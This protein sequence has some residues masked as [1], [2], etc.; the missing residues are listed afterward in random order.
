MSAGITFEYGLPGLAGLVFRRVRCFEI[1]AVQVAMWDEGLRAASRRR[2]RAIKDMPATRH[3]R[4]VLEPD[5]VLQSWTVLASLIALIALLVAHSYGMTWI[6]YAPGAAVLAAMIVASALLKYPATYIP[7]GE[8][9]L[10]IHRG[11]CHDAILAE[12]SRRKEAHFA[13]M[14]VIDP[15]KSIRDN[16]KMLRWLVDIDAIPIETY[17]R[18][19]RTLAPALAHQARADQP[20]LR[21]EQRRYL[22][23]T[24]FDMQSDRVLYESR[25]FG[26]GGS[27]FSVDYT[28]LPERSAIKEKQTGSPALVAT[29]LI[30][31]LF[32]GLGADFLWFAPYNDILESAI[33]MMWALIPIGL[34]GRALVFAVQEFRQGFFVIQEADIRGDEIIT[35]LYKRQTVAWRALA[36]PDPVL[37]LAEQTARLT[38]LKDTGVITD[39][40]LRR[41]TAE[42]ALH[43]S[44][45]LDLLPGDT[46]QRPT[47]LH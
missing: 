30:A 46:P 40:E 23:S 41:F 22:N 10:I 36:A 39:D 28:T 32:F 6:V 35:E 7:M 17:W 21:M 43:A 16:I 26:H 5:F 15:D 18:A 13:P 25:T 20:T 9:T 1:S 38:R 24:V 19:C 42:A 31:G 12:I 33:F 3:F 29:S 45:D 47:V 34:A 4:E 37:T 8:N 14:A 2:T 27:S 44:P 11:K